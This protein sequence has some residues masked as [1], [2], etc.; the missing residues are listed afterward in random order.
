MRQLQQLNCI[1]VRVV[2]SPRGGAEAFAHFRSLE[3]AIAC[4]TTNVCIRGRRA[5]CVLADGLSVSTDNTGKH[6]SRL[7]SP[8]SSRCR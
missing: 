2:C 7:L 3:D 8:Q 5:T 1:S 4:Q 6:R